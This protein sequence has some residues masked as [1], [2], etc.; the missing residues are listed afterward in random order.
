MAPLLSEEHKEVIHRGLH[1]TQLRLDRA[2]T[3]SSHLQFKEIRA[4][5][6][7]QAQWEEHYDKVYAP[8]EAKEKQVAEEKVAEPEAPRPT[9]RRAT[10]IPALRRVTQNLPVKNHT[11]IPAGY[12]DRPALANEF[13]VTCVLDYHAFLFDRYEYF[14]C[15]NPICQLHM[16]CGMGVMPSPKNKAWQILNLG[17]FKN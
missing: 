15:K 2:S 11:A 5:D 10:P 17:G 12:F 4:I 1:P 7:L 8:Q 3:E 14:S 13:D 9:V 6:N 16:R